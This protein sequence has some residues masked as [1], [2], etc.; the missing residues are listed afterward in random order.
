MSDSDF[1]DRITDALAGAPGVVAVV[2][3]GSRALGTHHAGSDYDIGLYY[4]PEAPIDTAALAAIVADLDDRRTGEAVT[5]IGEW[6]PWINGG[7]WLSI[8]GQAVDLLYRDLG[9]VEHCLSEALEGRYEAAYQSG[10]PHTFTSAHYLG[11][12]A[13]CR[14]LHD[15]GGV[16]AA[17]KAALSPYPPALRASLMARFGWEAGFSLENAAK[18]AKHGDIAYVAGCL[19]RSI[20]CLHQT[21]FALNETWLINEKG[22][23]AAVARL[24][25]APA[26]FQ[27]RVEAAMARLRPGQLADAIALIDELVRETTALRES[28][29][30]QV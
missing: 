28:P 10:H 21:L 15:P 19:W 16:V 12:A 23:T 26:N 17:L 9:K 25:L 30:F 20:G 1:L 11:E 7:A 22:A 6:G 18:G 5:R 27:G 4:R 8:G 14:P 24:A 13:L 29:T 3:G 2:L